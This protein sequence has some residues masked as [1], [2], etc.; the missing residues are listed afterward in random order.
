MYNFI[1]SL[2]NTCKVSYSLGNLTIWNQ[3]FYWIII[4]T[5]SPSTEPYGKLPV[6]CQQ[7][8]WVPIKPGLSTRD[9]L[10]FVAVRPIN[11]EKRTSCDA[12]WQPESFDTKERAM[13][14]VRRPKESPL[15]G[16]HGD[17]TVLVHFHV[18]GR[19]RK[20]TKRELR[21]QSNFKYIYSYF[22][23]LMRCSPFLWVYKGQSFLCISLPLSP[24]LSLFLSFAFS[25]KTD[26]AKLFNWNCF[27]L[28]SLARMLNCLSRQFK[29]LLLLFFL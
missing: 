4:Y 11:W 29:A 12:L 14:G 18:Y 21:Q 3:S 20:D 8:N 28:L 1:R 19:V 2:L 27:K 22:F 6:C 17:K 9:L 15:A 23:R 24:S 25:P 10:S 5:R 26:N 7:A 13:A 16:S